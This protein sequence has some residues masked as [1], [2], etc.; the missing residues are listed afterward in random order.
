MNDSQL[1]ASRSSEETSL[2]S[3]ESLIRMRNAGLLLISREISG[4]P[5]LCAVTQLYRTTLSIH[6]VRTSTQQTS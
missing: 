4:V 6:S 1:I 2:R 3:E 5:I